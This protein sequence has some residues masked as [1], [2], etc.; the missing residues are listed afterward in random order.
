MNWA[1]VP[2]KC[3]AGK[4]GAVTFL[5]DFIVLFGSLAKMIQVGIANVLDDKVVNNK[6]KHDGAPF[7]AP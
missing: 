1:G 3:H 7:V 4:A 2:F 6:C 5:R